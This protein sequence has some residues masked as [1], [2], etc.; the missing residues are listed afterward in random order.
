MTKSGSDR[1]SCLSSLEI[2]KQEDREERKKSENPSEHKVTRIGIRNTDSEH[3]YSRSRQQTGKQGEGNNKFADQTISRQFTTNYPEPALQVT[4]TNPSVKYKP[5]WTTEIKNE[6]ETIKKERKTA[7]NR[8]KSFLGLKTDN[9]RYK[10][11]RPKEKIISE[12]KAR[13]APLF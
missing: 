7:L 3:N 11:L 10:C 2:E 8:C 9:T 1:S 5:S 6:R 12:D 4:Q 13:N